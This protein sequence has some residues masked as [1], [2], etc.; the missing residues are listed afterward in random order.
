MYISEL[1]NLQDLEV[2]IESGLISK[3]KHP[4][5]PLYI[6]NYTAA[7]QFD[8]VWNDVTLNCRG[9]VVDEDYNIVA[10]S[11]PK[12]FSYEQLDGK[13]PEGEFVVEEKLDGS[14][15]LAF[16]YNGEL[17][18]AT[19][20]SFESEQASK[21]QDF[22]KDFNVKDG[23]SWIFEIIYKENRIVVDYDFEGLVLLDVND[24]RVPQ[25]KATENILNTYAKWFGFRRPK[26]YSFNSLDEILNCND[27]N[28]EGFVLHYANG[29]RVK[30]KTDDYKRLHR[31]VTGVSEKTVWEALKENRF[32][33]LIENVP[34]EF[35]DWVHAVREQLQN[36]YKVI[37]LRASWDFNSIEDK[38]DRKE[39]ALRA[40][41]TKYP[42]ILFKML[43]DKLQPE[44]IWKLC[45]PE[46][47]SVFKMVREDSN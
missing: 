9:L 46:V 22:L 7:A 45:K 21:A 1:M 31:L 15:L 32:S 25:L 10:R 24:L 11:F 28:I 6:L 44:M 41:E 29:E 33:E 17:I 36:K 47:T 26:I 35:Y 19:R 27:S 5:H 14:M 12:F 42:Q 38:S 23:E 18:T 13:L 2:A 40:M 8:W 34:D 30:I 4:I 43:D 20:G 39:F 16:R 37:L 3:R